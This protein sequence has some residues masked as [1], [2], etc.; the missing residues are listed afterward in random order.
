MDPRDI[1]NERVTSIDI[2]GENGLLLSGYKNGSVALWDLHEYKLLKHI[3][4]VH[5]SDITKVKMYSI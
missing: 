1:K 5:E 2:D 4:N 3:P